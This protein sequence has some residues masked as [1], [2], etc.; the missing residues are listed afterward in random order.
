MP[1]SKP[2][3]R[4]SANEILPAGEQAEARALRAVFVETG[5]ADID[6]ELKHPRL[7]ESRR[8]DPGAAGIIDIDKGAH[9]VGEPDDR[10]NRFERQEV[11][12]HS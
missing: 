3:T 2:F 6:A 11:I 1:N 8:T 9:I 7:T 12:G 10:A 4:M 5:R